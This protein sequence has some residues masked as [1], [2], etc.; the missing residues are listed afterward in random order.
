MEGIGKLNLQDVAKGLI[1]AILG[2]AAVVIF[3]MLSAPNLDIFSLDWHV[4]VNQA[5]NGAI[6]AGAGYLM[7]NLLSTSD[8][9]FMG[10]I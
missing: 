5:V 3:G 6:A 8:G 9:K 10:K 1:S 2:G 4:L 7:K